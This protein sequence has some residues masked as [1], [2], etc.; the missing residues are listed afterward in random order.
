[1]NNTTTKGDGQV[2][3]VSRSQYSNSVW[4]KVCKMSRAF[5][6]EYTGSFYTDDSKAKI[7]EDIEQDQLRLIYSD[8]QLV[9]FVNFDIMGSKV[10]SKRL[11]RTIN[12]MYIRPQHRHQ[13]IAT[14]ARCLVMAEHTDPQC[15]GTVIAYDRFMARPEYWYNQGLKYFALAPHNKIEPGVSVDQ[16]REDPSV[17]VTLVN[18]MPEGDF[19][20]GFWSDMDDIA[21]TMTPSTRSKE[22][23]EE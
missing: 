21:H 23:V 19:E 3:T 8:H 11:F 10:G 6:A 12:T 4:H 1:M 7:R 13:G 22:A 14:Q 2:I 17:L 5:Q 16:L 15:I 9:G 20:Q 18:Q